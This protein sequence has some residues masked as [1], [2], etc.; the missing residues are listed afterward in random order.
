MAKGAPE[1]SYGILDPMRQYSL[2]AGP[3]IEAVSSLLKCGG[4]TLVDTSP[5]LD[6]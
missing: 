1:A 4:K 3:T 2:L 6:S 5:T